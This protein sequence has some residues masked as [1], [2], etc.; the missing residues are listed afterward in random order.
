MV[1]TQNNLL[2]LPVTVNPEEK[3]KTL[4]DIAT[5]SCRFGLIFLF[6]FLAGTALEKNTPLCFFTV[7]FCNT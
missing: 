6:S 3:K 4:D 5:V 1:E 7:G 2:P